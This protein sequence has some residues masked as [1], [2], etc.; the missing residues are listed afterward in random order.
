M[1]IIKICESKNGKRI[2]II[3]HA[4]GNSDIISIAKAI[5]LLCQADKATLATSR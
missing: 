4:N 2:A 3:R 1:K 5:Q